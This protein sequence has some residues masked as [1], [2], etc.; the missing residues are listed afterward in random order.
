MFGD[1][2]AT[3]CNESPA[4]RVRGYVGFRSWTSGTAKEP[5]WVL[6]DGQATN[7]ADLAFQ[8]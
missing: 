1:R 7:A 2:R 6:V 5:Q 8:T 4:E 3:L